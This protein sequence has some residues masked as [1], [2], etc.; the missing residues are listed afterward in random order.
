MHL[1]TAKKVDKLLSKHL[2]RGYAKKVAD[3]LEKEG[4]Q[5][6][7]STVRQVKTLFL[8][9]LQTLNT[10]IELAIKTKADAEAQKKKLKE[11]TS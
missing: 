11:L 4:K 1:H 8:S 3:S 2:P 10:L 6:T 7:A 5:I 9:D